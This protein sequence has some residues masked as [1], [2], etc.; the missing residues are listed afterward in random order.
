MLVYA[1]NRVPQEDKKETDAAGIRG[2]VFLSGN[3]GLPTELVTSA[4]A[5]D[6]MPAADR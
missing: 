5:S 3:S 6:S 1:T 4:F 2:A